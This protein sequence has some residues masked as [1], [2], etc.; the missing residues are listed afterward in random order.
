M[1][2]NP[3]Q[4][5]EW[6]DHIAVTHMHNKI[7][8]KS[9][10]WYCDDI[11][12]DSNTDDMSERLVCFRQ[13]MTHIGQHL[14]AGVGLQRPIRPDFALVRHLC[15]E[16]LCDESRWTLAMEFDENPYRLPK[17]LQDCSP[18]TASNLQARRVPVSSVNVP[19]TSRSW[20]SSRPRRE[21]KYHT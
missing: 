12:F 9:V 5:D 19:Q 13:R 20:R 6:I 8:R 17:D 18:S 11:E 7:P 15:D 2:Y 3:G 10:C 16:G 4:E 21:Q 1:T 14:M